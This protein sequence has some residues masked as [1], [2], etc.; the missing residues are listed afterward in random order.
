MAIDSCLLRLEL[1]AAS[2]LLWHHPSPCQPPT[3]AAFAHP[4]TRPHKLCLCHSF[5]VCRRAAAPM[6]RLPL[7]LLSSPLRCALLTAPLPS[8]CLQALVA[9]RARYG[10]LLVVDEAH[11][12]LV[13]GQH[14]GGA[15]EAAGVE[16]HIDVHTGTRSTE[17]ESSGVCSCCRGAGG[18]GSARAF[19]G[20]WSGCIAT[21]R[22][23]P[24][25][26]PPSAQSRV[27]APAPCMYLSPLPPQA[28]SARPL[29]PWVA[30]WPAAPA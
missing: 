29:A 14:G 23:T 26:S 21:E 28:R 10:F 20:Q 5:A 7:L 15:A 27:A 30:L 12:T 22:H 6:P 3:P 2:C 18:S 24:T 19:R 4:S 9:L 25:L 11:A 16:Q 13:A 17:R 1:T 8:P